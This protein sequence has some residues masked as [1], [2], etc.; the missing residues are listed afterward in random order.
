MAEGRVD[1]D[2]AY[3]RLWQGGK[4]SRVGVRWEMGVILFFFC[5]DF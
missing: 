3:S 2:V 1:D 5:F 4:G